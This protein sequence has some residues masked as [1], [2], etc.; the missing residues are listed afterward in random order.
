VGEVDVHE[1]L[2]RSVISVFC[3]PPLAIGVANVLAES[4]SHGRMPLLLMKWTLLERD[5]T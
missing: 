5:L 1:E 4:P 2:T 3:V